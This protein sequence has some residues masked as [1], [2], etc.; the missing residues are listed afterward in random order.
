VTITFS[1]TLMGKFTSVLHHQGCVIVQESS[2]VLEMSQPIK[3][4][5]KVSKYVLSAMEPSQ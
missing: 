5:M 2:D 3:P 4:K 1:N